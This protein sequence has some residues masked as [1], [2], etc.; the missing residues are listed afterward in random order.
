MRSS[1][2]ILT[3]IVTGFC[4]AFAE[5]PEKVD[6]R[7]NVGEAY[8]EFLDDEDYSNV[9]TRKAKLLTLR[10]HP[11]FPILRQNPA[12]N[13]RPVD[14][15]DPFD[16]LRDIYTLPPGQFSFFLYNIYALYVRDNEI[17]YLKNTLFI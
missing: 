12:Y 9:S 15:G 1:V 5:V 16:F 2:Y 4:G 3:L 10:Y 17:S 6:D 13:Y 8:T 7:N 11:L 14:A